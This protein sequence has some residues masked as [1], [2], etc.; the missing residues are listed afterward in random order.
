MSNKKNDMNTGSDLFVDFGDDIIF[1]DENENIVQLNNNEQSSVNQSC[2]NW[3]F[4]YFGF[5]EINNNSKVLSLIS[6]YKFENEFNNNRDL[7]FYH[8]TSRKNK[9]T[10]DNVVM[11]I[12]DLYKNKNLSEHSTIQIEANFNLQ[13][14]SSPED[15][16]LLTN[17]KNKQ[18]IYTPY[19][20][21]QSIYKSKNTD[22]LK[23]FFDY[24]KSFDNTIKY[25]VKNGFLLFDSEEDL[26]K[27]NYVLQQ[28]MARR[29][30]ARYRLMSYH[31][32]LCN[33][34]IDNVE[35]DHTFHQ[36]YCCIPN[37]KTQNF[38]P[39]LWKGLN[40]LFLEAMYEN[41]IFSA[42]SYKMKNNF[43]NLSCYLIPLG[44]DSGVEQKQVARAIQRACHIAS[45]K[46]IQLNV[47]L[48]HNNNTYDDAYSHIS[49]SY[50]MGYV[51]VNS[52]W[53]SNF[54]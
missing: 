2:D 31:S 29:R 12:K 3:F 20:S 34:V 42:F 46:D 18:M 19:D 49:K 39:N 53:D 50:P 30:E 45:I 38:S 33:C 9:V 11:D 47:K 16:T 48:I 5:N 28:D 23:N 10:F 37:I 13:C 14:N 41:A 27:V 36:I 26:K 54:Y 43:A 7:N 6:K 21:L 32:N 4:K 44:C 52:V 35:Y 15:K 1:S 24:I 51:N 17:Y 22:M 8:S 40:E 25:E